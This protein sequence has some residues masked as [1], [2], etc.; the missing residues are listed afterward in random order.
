M[1]Q[2]KHT[3]ALM[4]FR[5]DLRLFDKATPHAANVGLRKSYSCQRFINEGYS[6][7]SYIS[8]AK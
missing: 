2:P 5:R 8:Q 3:S 6:P 7:I 1:L 4:W